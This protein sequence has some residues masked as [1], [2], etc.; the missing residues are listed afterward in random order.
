MA[1]VL[2]VALALRVGAALTA[3]IDGAMNGVD[4]LLTF[5]SAG[6]GP[7]EVVL[8]V[9]FAALCWWCAADDVR[10]ARPLAGIGA[11]LVAVQVLLTGSAA[12]AS[13][14][15][16]GLSLA[17]R[18]AGLL[19][20]LTWLVV[21]AVTAV[22]LLRVARSGGASAPAAE[23][24][25][26]ESPE[27]AAVEPVEQPYREAAGW[28]P[29]EAAGAVWTSAGEAAKGAAAADW[30][31]RTASGPAWGSGE[32]WGSSPGGGISGEQGARE[33]TSAPEQTTGR[34]VSADP[35]PAPRAEAPPGWGGSASTPNRPRPD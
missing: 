3:L 34:E 19:A 6:V 5:A 9:A 11:A 25:D 12:I 32:V 31:R 20:Q 7:G 14:L 2:L 27:I 35:G 23:P 21:P 13:F 29:D 22:V 8:A 16:G 18:I 28:A 4:P 33:V 24:A 15:L 10:G 30:G 1:V 26:P 17:S